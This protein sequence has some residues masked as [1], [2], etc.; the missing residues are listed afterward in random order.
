MSEKLEDIMIVVVG[1]KVEKENSVL[2]RKLKTPSDSELGCLL[3]IAFHDKK[4]DFVSI[5]R[6]PQP[7]SNPC[8]SCGDPVE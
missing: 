5:R 3:N 4:C 6:I 1:F 8:D 7:Q 2:Y